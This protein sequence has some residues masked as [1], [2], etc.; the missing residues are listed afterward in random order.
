MNTTGNGY[1]EPIY[2]I[3]WTAKSGCVIENYGNL[4]VNLSL[5]FSSNGTSL[6]QGGGSPPAIWWFNITENET[7]SCSAGMHQPAQYYAG[8]SNITQVFWT[9][10]SSICDNLSSTTSGNNSLRIDFALRIPYDAPSGTKTL[11][12]TAIGEAVET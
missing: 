2:C 9:N 1:V 11:N 7:G 5:N 10:G 4:R 12:M 6:I 8:W 3:Q